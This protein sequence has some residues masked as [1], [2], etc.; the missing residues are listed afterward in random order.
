MAACGST[1]T[2]NAGPGTA[3]SSVASAGS[4]GSAPATVGGG[5]NT[6]SGGAGA[7]G[8]G[9]SAGTG[10]SARSI[11][12]G[13]T[14]PGGPVPTGFKA[15]S[16]TYVSGSQAFVLGNA[17]CRKAPCTSLVRTLDG[18]RTWRGVPAP[19]AP[20]PPV[21]L[22]SSTS[23][24]TVQNVRFAGPSV[25]YA[26]GGGL[27]STHDAARTWHKVA[28]GG[29]VLG[30]ETDGTTVYAVT[31][32]C[33]SGTCRRATLL[34]SPVSQ[35]RFRQVSGVG[36]VASGGGAVSIGA[37][38]AVVTFGGAVYVRRGTGAWTH[39]TSPCSMRA[40]VVAPASGT[41]L[42]GFCGEG[43]AGSLYFS[44]FRSTNGGATW[45]AFGT[46]LRLTNGLDSLAAGSLS[47]LAGASA[48]PDTGGMLVV[49]QNGGASW[50]NAGV[51]KQSVGWRYVGARSATTL[52]ALAQLPTSG[53]WVSATAGRTWTEYRI[54]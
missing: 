47:V 26:F 22:A 29:T 33:T 14:L 27:W 13:V 6:S 32:D 35:D 8:S 25:G 46:P 24:A 17:P 45:T 28:L 43:A 12:S 53:I 49:S 21:N 19:V 4:T 16:V 15:W 1:G 18:G 23:T 52:V 44:V 48:N 40:S 34:T 41:A 20:L 38:Q 3:T 37:G 30:L 42:V 54:R 2:H 36:P 39:R 51:P 9:G 11:G 7:A 50:V 10:S 31:A 5:Q